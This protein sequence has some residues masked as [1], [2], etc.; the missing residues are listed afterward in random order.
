MTEPRTVY[1]AMVLCADH[2]AGRP[3]TIR[4]R[5]PAYRGFDGCAYRVGNQAYIDLDPGLAD[6]YAFHA[7]LHEIGHIK[8]DFEALEMGS[9]FLTAQPGSIDPGI[10]NCERTHNTITKAR[11]SRADT[12]YNVWRAWA[13]REYKAFGDASMRACWRKLIA[14]C[15]WE[16]T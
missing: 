12:W 6:G 4:M 9:D 2:L 1:D 16:G 13:E 14:L 10:I 7:L 3:V 8:A 5:K 11:E 15:E